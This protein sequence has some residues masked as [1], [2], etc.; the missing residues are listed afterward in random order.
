MF[1]N[2]EKMKYEILDY[3]KIKTEYEKFILGINKNNDYDYVNYCIDQIEKIRCDVESMKNLAYLK[4]NLDVKNNFYKNLI[5]IYE[6][7]YFSRK[8]LI[9]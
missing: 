6:I 5:L 7:F 1:E 4:F 3:K 9:D 2:G 8:K